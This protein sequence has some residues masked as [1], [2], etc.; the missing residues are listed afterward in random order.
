M[1]QGQ[2]QGQGRGRGRG[3]GRQAEPTP[4]TI[5]ELSAWFAG[6]IADDWFTEPASIT[7]LSVVHCLCQRSMSKRTRPSQPTNE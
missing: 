7:L 4:T 5:H 3:R 6:N 1:P 2:G